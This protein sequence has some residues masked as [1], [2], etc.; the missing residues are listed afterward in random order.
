MD[1][2]YKARK[3]AFV[4]NLAGG[5]ILEINAVSLVAPV[6]ILALFLAVIE[7]LMMIRGPLGLDLCMVGPAVP[8]V[9]L[10]TLQP[11]SAGGR[12]LPQCPGHPLR[13]NSVLLGT[14]GP[15]SS[16]Y[17]SSDPA[18]LQPAVVPRTA[19]GETPARINSR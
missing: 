8:T 19:K 13:D 2:S 17:L 14:M 1:P 11:S 6:S 18:A 3:E 16:P 10:H 9:L 7:M 12:F 15:E 5:T 4:S